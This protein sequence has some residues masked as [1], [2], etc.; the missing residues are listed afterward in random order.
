[1][2][3]NEQQ[4]K[5]LKILETHLQVIQTFVDENIVKK[6][7]A[8]VS[9]LIYSGLSS[10]IP[11]VDEPSFKRSF[12][13][14]V[15]VGNIKGIYGA[16]R[17]GFKPI[18]DSG[19]DDGDT[20]PAPPPIPTEDEEGKTS[21]RISRS[22]RLCGVD[23]RNWA[24]QKLQQ[25]NDGYVWL[26]MHYWPDLSSALRGVTKILLNKEIKSVKADISGMENV[27][28]AIGEA[29]ERIYNKMLAALGETTKEEKLEEVA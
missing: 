15:K 14:N 5:D 18:D 2:S 28:K 17:A 7:K 22:L 11:D 1:M 12:S 19:V 16:K 10:S 8:M 29:E 13:L 23:K 21:I 4:Q 9:S 20:L 27:I 25:V 24:F 6:N 3:L 26:S